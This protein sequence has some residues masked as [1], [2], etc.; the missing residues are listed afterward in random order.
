MRQYPYFFY[1]ILSPCYPTK[2]LGKQ[3]CQPHW[4]YSFVLAV[5]QTWNSGRWFSADASLYFACGVVC[6]LQM[7]PKKTHKKKLIVSLINEH[8]VFLICFC[9]FWP[10]QSCFL[11]NACTAL[12]KRTKK[13]SSVC[14]SSHRNLEQGSITLSDKT[15]LKRTENMLRASSL[16]F[17]CILCFFTGSFCFLTPQSCFLVNAYSALTKRT[18]K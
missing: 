13:W 18:Q 11:F 3:H 1:Q 17:Y 2:S 15:V 4:K 12:T 8:F 9:Y 5:F 7:Y 14:N 16:L 10:P 6:V